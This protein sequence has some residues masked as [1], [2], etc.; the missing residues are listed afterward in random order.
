MNILNC[1]YFEELNNKE[2]KYTIML[3]FL[4]V[5]SFDRMSR[6]MNYLWTISVLFLAVV[7]SLTP[8]SAQVIAQ[9]ADVNIYIFWGEG[10]PHCEKARPVLQSFANADQRINYFEFEVY[11][12]P[13]NIDLFFEFAAIHSFD[14]QGVPT[15]FIG[16]RY[17]VGY[18]DNIKSEISAYL[19]EC[20]LG[21]CPD[22]GDMIPSAATI[23]SMQ[24]AE[25]ITSSKKDSGFLGKF[26]WILGSAIGVTGIS[27][28]VFR[29]SKSKSKR[30]LKRKSKRKDH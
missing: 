3:G 30:K 20:L 1:G 8:Q 23:L 27:L 10:C 29:G 15:I 19:D 14:P 6:I 7:I 12:H 28:L 22:P 25:E 17:W 11:H 24:Q 26:L 21:G 2:L 18:S 13:E 9:D 5:R 16:D 4:D